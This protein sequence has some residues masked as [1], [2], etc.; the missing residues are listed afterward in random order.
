MSD[1]LR[2]SDEAL[3]LDG[4][5]FGSAPVQGEG[6]IG[7]VPFYFRARW[8]EWTFAVA[9]RDEAD[10]VLVESSS[11]GFFRS[12]CVG[13]R[14]EASYMSLD[15]AEELIRICARAYMDEDMD[16]RPK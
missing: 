12:G 10:P 14:D 8:N 3:Q 13:D 4:R 11:A 16:L 15:D 7:G 9:S 1:E 5:I 2:I 6:R